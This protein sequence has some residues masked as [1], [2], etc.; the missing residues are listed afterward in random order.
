MTRP[1]H[2]IESIFM[3]MKETATYKETSW[4]S[5]WQDYRKKE[6]KRNS[7]LLLIYEVLTYQSFIDR[8]A[9]SPLLPSNKALPV[10][11]KGNFVSIW[12][13]GRGV[14]G[15]RLSWDGSLIV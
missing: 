14:G 1:W 9:V 12:G 4:Y 8:S 2:E 10:N 3:R 13:G 11:S 15:I 6:R 7:K 5:G